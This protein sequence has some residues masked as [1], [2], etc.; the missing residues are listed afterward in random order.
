[1]SEKDRIPELFG[2]MSFN[3]G[4]ME[5]YV[6]H[7][8]ME[9]WRDCLKSGKPL[10]LTAANDIA[11][12]MKTWALEHGATHFTH[13]F[14]PLTGITAE[15]HDSF[16]NPIGGGKI[17]MDFSGKELVCGEP[18]ASSFPSGGLCLHQGRQPLHPDGVLLLR[19]RG[20]GQEDP[21]AALE[22]G[23]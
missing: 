21:A 6:P 8:A 14:Q 12:A 13:W 10:P 22:R 4:T 16:I 1:M 23:G 15:K 3:E 2:S 18:D 7:Q 11:E 9:V 19:R 5:Q 20:A 17:I